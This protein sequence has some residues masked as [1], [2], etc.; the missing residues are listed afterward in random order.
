MDAAVTTPE[1][2]ERCDPELRRLLDEINRI[3][4]YDFRG[5]ASSSI[6][7]CVARAQS[8]LD[9]QSAEHLLRR[10]LSDRA[11][12]TELLRHLTVQT[13][14][15]FRDPEYFSALR[16]SVLPH[17]ATYPSIRIWVAG[18]GMGEE[19]CSLAI[20]L[21]EEGLLERSMI[22][23]TDIDPDSL[24]AARTGVYE[25]RRMRQFTENYFLAGGKASPSDYYTSAYSKAAFAPFLRRRVLYCDHSL[26][27]DTE[28]AEVQLVSCRNVL[29]Y[30]GREL[31]DR[32]IGLFRGALCP[33]GFLGIGAKET[34][35]FS[36]HASTFET[37]APEQRIYRRRLNNEIGAT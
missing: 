21:H 4:H 6:Q 34:V 33:G 15:F 30:F 23:A 3:Y 11:V 24:Q 27:T 12:F 14:E 1:T 36:H 7:R 28:F 8:S 37:F 13:S 17:L 35:A 19:A 20:L 9:C 18:C 5:Y 22:Y 26:A 16:Q 10:V 25:V 2:T 31:Q 32:A 29:I